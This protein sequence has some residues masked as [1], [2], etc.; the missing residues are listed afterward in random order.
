MFHHYKDPP[1]NELYFSQDCIDTC[2]CEDCFHIAK[3]DGL[4]FRKCSLDHSFVQ[5]CPIPAE[6]K[7]VAARFVDMETLE[8]QKD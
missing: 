2:F 7:D 8:V 3:R 5:V 6:A 1:F 4:P